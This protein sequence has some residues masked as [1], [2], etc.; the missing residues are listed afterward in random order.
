MPL[1]IRH[2]PVVQNWDCHVCGNCCKEY[3]VAITEEER[4]RIE[5]QAWEADA[6][7]AGTPLFTVE[8]PPW[9]R[10]TTL[11]RR[12][13]GSCVFLSPSGRCRMHEKFGAASKPLPCRLYPFVLLP[14][15]DHWR[16]GLRY[17]CPSAAANKGRPLRAHDADLRDYA[18][19]LEGREELAKR[20]EA[21]GLP[22]PWLQAGQRVG[23]DDLFRVVGAIESILKDGNEPMERRLRKCLALMR[24][25]RAARFESITGRRLDE[26]LTVLRGTLDAEV[27][28]DA[29][30]LSA[31]SW[32]GR[33]LFR[34]TVALFARMDSGPDRGPDGRSRMGL[35]RS[36]WC[37]ARGR[38]RVP[39][40]NAKLSL[41][42]FE[43][44]EEAHPKPSPEEDALLERYYLTKVGS[45]QFCG[46]GYFEFD[47]WD[48][49]AALVITLPA[50]HWLART[51]EA[52]PRLEAVAR[53]VGMVDDH[54]GYNRA[55]ASARQ[56]VGLRILVRSGEL[57]RLIG[58]YSR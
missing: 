49:F 4:K 15:G 55:L 1:P 12:S 22:P 9:S 52:V 23:W 51:Q 47:F 40:L 53:A 33:V 56:R 2:L 21:T 24:L 35:L 26:F 54:F 6:E 10:T 16:V 18:R 3:P 42:T 31:P 58:W 38:G 41:T 57:D 34:Q 8:G 44:V 46:P 28:A 25:C 30:T 11:N 37:F 19:L 48:G 20:R 32:V 39:H 43:K 27:P 7:L 13:D 14:A 5:G 45:L 50:I 17:A 36:A 29:A